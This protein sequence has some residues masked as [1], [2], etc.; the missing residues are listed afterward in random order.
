MR[1]QLARVLRVIVPVVFVLAWFALPALGAKEPEEKPP[2][3]DVEGLD[4]SKVWVPWVAAFLFAV[5]GLIAAFK[6]PHRS[7]TERT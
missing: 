7:M 6:N 4:H 5:A 1:Q 3:Y 2:P